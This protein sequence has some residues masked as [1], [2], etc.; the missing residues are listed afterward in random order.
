MKYAIRALGW[1]TAILWILVM[2][3]S[4]TVVYSAMQIR[5]NFE[6]EPQMTASEDTVT[7]SIPFTVDN[8]GF[9]DISELNITTSFVTEAGEVI[10]SSTTLVPSILRD[11]SV[12]ETHDITLSLE[13]ILAKNLSYLLLNDTDLNI[14]MFVALTYA[15]AIPLKISSNLTMQWGAPL[16][17]LTVRDVSVTMTPPYT[18]DVPLSFENHAFFGLDGNLTLEIFD[19]SDNRIGSK[20]VPISVPP[21]TSYADVISITINEIPSSG[22]KEVRLCFKT[23]VFSFGPLVMPL[24]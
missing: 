17:N 14:N 18:V 6:E 16:S 9:Y 2:V 23:S 11:S 15:H 24:E 13:E 22:L 3:F 19:G 5:M 4:V 1:A 20:I 10:A 12:N 21:G 7:M 8:G